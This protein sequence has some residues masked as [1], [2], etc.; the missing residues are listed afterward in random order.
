MQDSK[1]RVWLELG[2]FA[3]MLPPAV[4]SDKGRWPGIHHLTMHLM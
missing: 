2:C 4:V 1:V 3:I